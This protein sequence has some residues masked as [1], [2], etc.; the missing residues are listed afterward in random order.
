MIGEKTLLN[1]LRLV[2]IALSRCMCGQREGGMRPPSVPHMVM[3]YLYMQ[4]GSAPQ[5]DIEAEFGMRRSTASRLLG[6]LEESGCVR[7]TTSQGDGRSKRVELTEKAYAE[8]EK[9]TEKIR[10]MDDYVESA[11]T[12]EEKQEFFAFCDKLKTLFVAAQKKA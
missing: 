11:F 5:K 9:N 2:H 3:H 4:G 8:Q 6:K 10:K 12:A 1:E 7:R